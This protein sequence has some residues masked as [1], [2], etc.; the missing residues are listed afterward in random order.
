[1]KKPK[2]KKL[3]LPDAVYILPAAFV[4]GWRAELKKRE[5]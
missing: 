5:K 3:I 1:M 4:E 2:K